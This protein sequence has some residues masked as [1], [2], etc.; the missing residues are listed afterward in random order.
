MDALLEQNRTA[1][2]LINQ[3]TKAFGNKIGL[4]GKLFGCWHRNLT[5]PFTVENA[6][7]RSCLRCGARK[8]FDPKTLETFGSF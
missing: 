6:S 5:R 7:Y 1:E 3:T 2:S 8:Q 4:F